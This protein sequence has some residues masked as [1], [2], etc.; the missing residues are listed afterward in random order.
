MDTLNLVPITKFDPAADPEQQLEA[1]E[2]TESGWFHRIVLEYTVLCI[3][4]TNWENASSVQKAWAKWAASQ[5]DNIGQRMRAIL[6]Q[7]GGVLA[8][9][10][11]KGVLEAA[12]QVDLSQKTLDSLKENKEGL[13]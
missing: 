7:H 4:G 11:S 3:M 5:I 13:S 12:A 8:E 6:R 2:W 9:K 10:W 1:T